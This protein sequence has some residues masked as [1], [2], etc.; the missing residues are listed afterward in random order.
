MCRKYRNTSLQKLHNVRRGKGGFTLVELSVVMALVAILA[1][2][3]VSFSVL[4]NGFAKNNKIEYQFS[5]ESA[6]VKKSFSSW[7]TENDVMDSV[8]TVRTDGTLSVSVAG[9]EKTVSLLDSTLMI[10]GAQSAAYETVEG[11][12]FRANDKLIQCV[13]YRLSDEG[14]RIERSFVFSLRCG[15]LVAEEALDNA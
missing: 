14:E 2:M 6:A 13:I 9:E 11:M 8:F 7:V 15:T 4:M 5:E 1:T 10:D 12:Y 3:T